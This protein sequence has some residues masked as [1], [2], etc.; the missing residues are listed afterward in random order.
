MWKLTTNLITDWWETTKK[1]NSLQTFFNSQSP[2][3]TLHYLNLTRNQE[4]K[5]PNQYNKIN[6]P[7]RAQRTTKD[8]ECFRNDK[9]R[10][11]CPPYQTSLS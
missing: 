4:N 6:Y 9:Y 1:N 3:N 8:R 7:R 10:I 2:A 11:T 5:N